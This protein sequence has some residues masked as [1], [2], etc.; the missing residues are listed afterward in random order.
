M[1]ITKIEHLALAIMTLITLAGMF[2]FEM[3]EPD[4]HEPTTWSTET[5]VRHCA[6]NGGK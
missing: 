3:A 2:L 5:G 6:I 1:S 4:C